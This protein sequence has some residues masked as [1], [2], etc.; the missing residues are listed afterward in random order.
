MFK[1]TSTPWKVERTAPDENG[2]AIYWIMGGD[3][4][5][6]VTKTTGGGSEPAL[7]NA[8]QIVKAVNCHEEL[9]QALKKAEL[10]LYTF[11]PEENK[12]DYINTLNQIK[13]AILKAE[14]GS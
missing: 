13:Q 8:M 3:G 12:K 5:N 6:V 10:Y 14:S 1:Y 7:A 11:T 9:T 2:P 4:L